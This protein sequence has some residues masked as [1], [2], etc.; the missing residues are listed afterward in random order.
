ALRDKDVLLH[1]PFQ[2]FHPVMD[3]LRQAATDP[4]VLAI[5]L[6]CG[7]DPGLPFGVGMLVGPPTPNVLIG[8]FPCPPIGDMIFGALMRP[9]KAVLKAFKNLAS[10]RR[11]N[12]HC[13]DGSHPIYLVTGENFDEFTDFVS[14]GLFQWK[15]HYTTARNHVDGPLGFGFR[16]FYQRTLTVRLHESVFVDWDGVAQ[17]L[18]KFEKGENV[19]RAHGYVLRRISATEYRLSTRG[20]PVMEFRGDP[21]EGPL[22][23]VR[24][25]DGVCELNFAYD[26]SGRLIECE[27]R[28]NGH[29]ERRN[30]EFGH[31]FQGRLCSVVERSSSGRG[32]MIERLVYAYSEVGELM[33]ARDAIGGIWKYEYD[34]EHRWTKHTDP[35]GYSYSFAYDTQGRCVWASGQDGLWQASVEYFPEDRRTQYTAGDDAVWEFWYDR[36]GVVTK[37]INPQGG[38]KN[39]ERDERGRVIR[40]IDAGGRELRWLYDG[41][42]AHHARVDRF[43]YVYPPER[44]MPKLANPFARQLPDDALS[45]SFGGAFGPDKVAMYG[46]SSR[47]LDEIPADL[48]PLACSLFRF[49]T[50]P[51]KTSEPRLERDPLGRKIFEGD[52]LGCIRRWEYDATG[53]LIAR[54]DRDGRIRRW[55]T[56]SWNLVGAR[57]DPL[58]NTTGYQWSSI[59]QIVGLTDPLG[60]TTRWDYDKCER[61][62]RVWRHNRIWDVYEY[63]VGDHFVAKYDGEGQLVFRNVEIHSN[64]F[65]RRRELASGGEHR[66]DYDERGRIIEASTESHEVRMAYDS[67]GRRSLDVRDGKGLERHRGVGGREQ[68]RLL[69]RFEIISERLGTDLRITAPN[70]VVIGLRNEPDGVVLRECSN[71]TRDWQQYDHE[72][73]LIARMT[74]K[75][76]SLGDAAGLGHALHILGRGGPAR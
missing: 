17:S 9:L 38:V 2:S 30:Y 48:H 55:T 16:H 44:E 40:E 21:F 33:R 69:D 56:T 19:V 5:K 35:R 72:G 74:S 36:D 12:G 68:V 22:S 49:R 70:G 10:P 23:L 8:G 59:E 20:Q 75:H 58:G 46:T 29:V 11:A 47:L 52:E 14:G 6:L 25:S 61:L 39:R 13:A 28:G 50:D 65:V 64:H 26:Q 43:G 63:D 53:N 27:E 57:I 54:T 45:R 62:I 76:D 1:H 4:A 67:L 18:P 24:M 37:I 51:S 60:N 15:R 66:F 3:L 32:Q 34:A 71:G 42:G 7:K 73:R 41:D 31:D